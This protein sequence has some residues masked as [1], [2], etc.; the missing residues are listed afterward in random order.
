MPNFFYICAFLAYC[1]LPSIKMCSVETGNGFSIYRYLTNRIYYM[2]IFIIIDYCY[3]LPAM[4]I[5][6]DQNLEISEIFIV[7]LSSKDGEKCL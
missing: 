5:Q 2:Y 3:D 1:T 4:T 7:R 6:T